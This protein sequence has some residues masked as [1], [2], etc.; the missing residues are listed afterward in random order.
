VV[1]ATVLGAIGTAGSAAFIPEMLN[2]WRGGGLTALFAGLSVEALAGGLALGFVAR[3]SAGA[4][5]VISITRHDQNA[6][7]FRDAAIVHAQKA[8]RDI[9]KYE[10][11]LGAPANAEA[12]VL[13]LRHELSVV[14]GVLQVQ[15]SALSGQRAGRRLALYVQAPLP[16][17]FALGQFFKFQPGRDATGVDRWGDVVPAVE[18][19]SQSPG[20][21]FFD[22]VDIRDDLRRARRPAVM[23]AIPD[24][25][26]LKAAQS[27]PGLGNGGA[28]VVAMPV[29]GPN[30]A[31]IVQATSAL[32]MPQAALLHASSAADLAI[33][34]ALV[35]VVSSDFIDERKE[36]FESAVVET[37]EVVE[38][39]L[40]DKRT[41]DSTTYLYL[42]S[43]AAFALGLGA[44]IGK[45][46]LVPMDYV[47]G[48][49]V[50]FP[51]VASR[52]S[53]PV[54]PVG[55]GSRP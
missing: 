1:S 33:G 15:M 43:P 45:S 10:R 16:L 38:T 41:H 24:A 46:G 5:V 42:A 18:Q 27:M 53:G 20:S 3:R 37:C 7:G 17:V 22:A 44:L 9:F 11:T 52:S 55:E 29:E 32:A 13:A 47:G 26:D 34:E 35:L 12:S 8:A 51:V 23:P 2:R 30:R 25:V 50:P 4:A 39:W 49:Y 19:G 14:Q 40:A 48:R 31:V 6:V 28:L 54:V 36:S 21:D